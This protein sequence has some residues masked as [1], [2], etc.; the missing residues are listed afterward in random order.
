MI[1]HMDTKIYM[2]TKITFQSYSTFSK[3]EIQKCF[4][5]AFSKF[6]YVV[7][8]F[9]RFDDSSELSEVNKNSGKKV[10][11]SKEMY[12]LVKFSLQLADKT[13]GAFDPTIID[14]L[15]AYGYDKHYEF[16][17]LD[18]RKQMEIEIEKIVK[19]RKSFKE[20]EL[21]KE[22]NNYF[23]MLQNGQRIDLGGCGKGYAIDLAY[24]ELLTLQNFLIEAGGD[25]RCGGFA[26]DL[27][28]KNLNKHNWVIGLSNPDN[29]SE[30]IG[31]FELEPSYAIACSGSFARKVKYFHHL[32]DPLTGKPKEGVKSTFV[33]APTA[34]IADAYATASYIM[35][36]SIKDILPE[37]VKLKVLK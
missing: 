20:I 22:T 1:F 21:I 8:K 15:E 30:N 28:S 11:V 33:S 4:D 17:K 24:K 18:N 16:S 14:I 23:I 7:K 32:I 2:N 31:N 36:D 3:E 29:P 35:G 10:K 6:D 13:N 26:V 19:T 34:M 12:D 27:N 9:S 37:E 5:K 25:I